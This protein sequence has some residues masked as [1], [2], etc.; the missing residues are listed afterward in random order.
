MEKTASVPLK[1]PR[2]ALSWIINLLFYGSICWIIAIS[3]LPPVKGPA[4]LM[5]KQ[6][7]SGNE[8]IFRFQDPG[9]PFVIFKQYLPRKGSVSFL[10]DLPYDPQHAV[11]EQLQTAQ[12]QMAPLLLNPAPV[13]NMALVFCSNNEIAAARMQTAGYRVVR[14]LGNGKLIAEKRS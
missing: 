1:Q 6:F 12:G 10:T 2:P 11:T 14:V 13:E 5:Q 8:N 9:L 7:F 4:F 3:E